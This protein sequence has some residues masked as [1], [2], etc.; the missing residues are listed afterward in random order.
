MARPRKRQEHRRVSRDR[1]RPVGSGTFFVASPPEKRVG[2][3]VL[4]V[5]FLS[6]VV[7]LV[8]LG[9]PPLD[10][11]PGE[12]AR[13]DYRARI[14]FE[15]DDIEATRSAREQAEQRVIRT[16]VD[17]SDEMLERKRDIKRFLQKLSSTPPA[18]ALYN[19]AWELWG[20]AAK[21]VDALHKGLKGDRGKQIVGQ[22][23]SLFAEAADRD[24]WD[25]ETRK[26]EYSKNRYRIKVIHPGA[27]EPEERSVWDPI[28]LPEGLE[29]H[30]TISLGG[31][32]VL[33][34]DPVFGQILIK[35]LT[36][37]VAPTLVLD[38]NRTNEDIARAARDVQPEQKEIFKDT[39][40]L[41]RGERATEQAVMELRREAGVYA[42]EEA[43]GVLAELRNVGA[44]IFIVG[45]LFGVLGIHI[46]R[47]RADLMRS[48]NRLFRVGLIGIGV[49]AV[50]KGVHL[51]GLPVVL[52]PLCG[53]ALIY[54]ITCGRG[55]AI[56]MTALLGIILGL[57]YHDGFSSVTIL[58]AGS[59]VGIVML[60][61]LRRR[62]DPIRVGVLIG[63]AQG[64]MVV[65]F[66]LVEHQEG[67]WSYAPVITSA[68]SGI[69]GGVVVGFLLTAFLPIIEGASGVVTDVTLLEWAD[70]NQPILRKLAIEAPGT[71]HHCMVVSSLAEAATEAVGGNTFLA[72]AGALLHDVGKMN[73]PEYF[74][75]N[76]P[77]DPS[78]RHREL[79]PQMSAL[80]IAAHVKDGL[81]L[82]R[83]YN[84]PRPIRHIIEQ[85][86]GGTLVESVYR[87]ALEQA[88][89]ERVEQDTFRY[90]GPRPRSKEAAIIL[91]ADAVESATRSLGDP[92][93][94][95]VEA[96]V[97][98]IC[99]RRLLDSQLDE[100]GLTFT[101][102]NLISRSF[103]RT[104]IA[105]FH[106]RVQ[107]PERQAD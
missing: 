105:V 41:R 60:G 62:I 94:A 68:C 101:D 39:I 87:R 12:R 36:R 20:L 24:L 2:R 15:I 96:L 107:Y 76:V 40:I 88:D 102:L 28:A 100:S 51:A 91:L 44:T 79:S 22:M 25:V 4:A 42:R 17:R 32:A 97:Q 18:Q 73:K 27:A 5:V 47:H 93:P 35:A 75:E 37:R 46:G 9:R 85:H 1:S 81:E 45:M 19:E 3:V 69:A 104:L 95:R 55:F 50:G 84:I 52:T 59:A 103:A 92:S 10:I 71:Y 38:E 90:R 6:A 53:A 57:M 78:K 30:F 34:D 89:G 61:E 80:V 8:V 67:V 49:L 65:A 13:R 83:N 98:E 31:L 23:D 16:Y 82:A 74:A 29:S 33:A 77:G 58:M 72:R 66:W 7:A 21:E 106:P 64:L 11:R 70:Q 63:A 86:H 26:Q 54:S 14:Y 43:P 99:R 48:N 56:G